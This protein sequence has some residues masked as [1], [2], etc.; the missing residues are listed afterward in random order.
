MKELRNDTAAFTVQFS[1]MPMEKV[2]G[3]D[4]ANENNS[5]V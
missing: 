2:A 3:R 5:T 1:A 4:D